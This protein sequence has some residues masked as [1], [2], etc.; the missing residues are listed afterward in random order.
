[1]RESLV[2]S[3][4]LL[5]NGLGKACD[6]LST[7]DF[8]ASLVAARNLEDLGDEKKQKDRRLKHDSMLSFSQTLGLA[9]LPL[10]VHRQLLQCETKPHPEH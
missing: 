2:S 3:Q 4:T 9:P 6:V 7:G 8:R 1:M 10:L 5:R